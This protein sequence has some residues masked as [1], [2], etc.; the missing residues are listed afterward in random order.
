MTAL[1]R[2]HLYLA[3]AMVLAATT[4][5]LMLRP[6]RKERPF[7]VPD[8]AEARAAGKL[9]AAAFIQAGGSTPTMDLAQAA[10]RFGLALARL[11]AP[12]GLALAEPDGQ[13]AGR[14]AFLFRTGSGSVPVALVAPHRGAD[15]DT[16]PL[17]KMLFEENPF[18]AAAWN[19]APRRSGELCPHSADVAR[20]PT[21]YLTAFSLAFA[22]AYPAGRV[23]QLHG[24]EGDKRA[25]AAARK[26]DVILSDGSR[27]PA[28]RLLDLADCLNH[29]FPGKQIAVFPIDS[30]ELGATS[31]AQGQALRAAGYTG[32]THVE[33]SPAFRRELVGDQTVR[34]RLAS[35]LGAGL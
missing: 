7:H 13:C 1:R 5:A 34:A 11:D 12:A 30:E 8:A 26:A 3:I 32:F 19:S 33:L 25:G 27:N 20:L 17:A 15:R 31:N 16:G 4:L 21:H 6:L 22:R 10:P 28:P 29:A 35:C 24:F 14:G 18:A 23:V 2:R 9:F